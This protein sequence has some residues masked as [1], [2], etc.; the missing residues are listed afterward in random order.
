ML[1]E[2]CILSGLRA[3]GVVTGDIEEM[4]EKR[5]G[6]LFMPHGLCQSTER[7]LVSHLKSP[8][9]AHACCILGT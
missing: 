4:L 5:I 8:V 3:A 6:A 1:A 2:Q 7:M 9:F